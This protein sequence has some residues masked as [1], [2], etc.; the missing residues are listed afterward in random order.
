M[1]DD[2]CTAVDGA[3][4]PAT[5]VCVQNGSECSCM[6]VDPCAGVTCSGSPAD[7]CHGA[8]ECDPETGSCVSPA[9]DGTTCA[10]LD[11]SG[12]PLFVTAGAFT[13]GQCEQ[14]FCVGD[15]TDYRASLSPA[16]D[17]DYDGILDTLQAPHCRSVYMLYVENNT[18]SV[19]YDLPHL[20]IVNRMIRISSNSADVTLNLPA[21]VANE[22]DGLYVQANGGSV[23]VAMPQITTLPYA[24]LSYN[25]GPLNIDLRRLVTLASNLDIQDNTGL[26][27]VD[28]RSLQET[29]FGAIQVEYNTQLGAIDITTVDLEGEIEGLALGSLNKVGTSIG[30]T[31]ISVKSNS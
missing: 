8:P 5:G 3:G 13:N 26:V 2:E 29:L 25:A 22:H 6:W 21:L 18:E 24:F 4:N 9:L 11:A 19:V 1:P 15:C 27:N 23:T 12:A 20:T 30:G 31:Y 7:E 10:G 14:G 28:L 17:W 16:G